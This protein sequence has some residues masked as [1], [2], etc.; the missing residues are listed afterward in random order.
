MILTAP[1]PNFNHRT[2]PIS[3]LVLHY[4]GMKTGVE[5]LAR[6]R[7]PTAKVSAHYLIEEDGHI[8]AMVAEHQRAWHAGLG[9]WRGITDVNSASIGI[10]I[11]NGGH[12][13]GLPSFAEP[14]IKAVITLGL[15]IV[16]RHNIAAHNIVGHSDIAPGR[17]TDPGE[18]FPWQHLAKTGLGQW[19]KHSDLPVD[20]AK[21]YNDLAHIGYGFDNA[22][23]ADII[24][25]F[26]RHFLPEAISGQPCAQTCALAH[27][28]ARL[29][30]GLDDAP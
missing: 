24:T 13:F 4:T 2:L 25:A 18:H 8:F 14:Q 26:Q 12:D 19:P 17:K 3:M 29:T 27:T 9:C 7:D 10:E 16:K 15:E 22:N 6:L 30:P 20:N 1:S 28:L 11:V 5:A 21:L 23:A